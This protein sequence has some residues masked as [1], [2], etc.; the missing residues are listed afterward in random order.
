MLNARTRVAAVSCVLVLLAVLTYGVGDVVP[1]RTL[2]PLFRESI[3]EELDEFFTEAMPRAETDLPDT[4]SSGLLTCRPTEGGTMLVC[5]DGNE[6]VEEEKAQ[7]G[8]TWFYI[9]IL[10]C[11]FC[12]MLGGCMSGLTIGLLSLDPVN[13]KILKKSGDADARKYAKGIQPLVDQHHL[14][15]VTLLMANAAAMESLPIFLDRL[16]HPAYAIIISV[17]AVLIFGEIVPQAICTRFGLSVGYYLRYF[18]WFV[19]IIFFVFAKPL[20]MILDCVFGHNEG[21]L[22][23]RAELK[24]LVAIHGMQEGDSDEDESGHHGGKTFE[25][26]RLT[27]DEITIIRGALDMSKKTVQDCMTPISRCF[28]LGS[29][30]KFDLK[31]MTAVVEAGHSRIPIYHKSKQNII[32]MILVKNLILLSPDNCTKVRDTVIRRVPSVPENLPLYDMLNI[33]QTGKSHMATV[34]DHKD[35]ITILGIITLEDV[36]EELIQEEIIDETDVYI[37]VVRQIRVAAAGRMGK[38]GGASASATASA[39]SY[40][41]GTSFSSIGSFLPAPDGVQGNRLNVQIGPAS[42]PINPDIVVDTSALPEDTPLLEREKESK[43]KAN[44][45]GKLSVWEEGEPDDT[46]EH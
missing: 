1:D 11:F 13:L 38:P 7:P 45:K 34:L 2:R 33:F 36:I 15:L 12:V 22:Y 27:R 16:V 5:N 28:M 26:Q 32:G 14:L 37:D 40:T 44:G 19:I 8:S 18:V 39:R 30:D 6:Y 21:T 17:T 23:R 3:N 9:D 41:Q 46:I 25:G 20:S 42:L 29:T 35:H 4:D 43:R 24:E 31:T 10:L